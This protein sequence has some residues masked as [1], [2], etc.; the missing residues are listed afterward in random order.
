M[1]SASSSSSSGTSFA[2]ADRIAR[3]LLLD[4]EDLDQSMLSY[5]ETRKGAIRMQNLAFAEYEDEMEAIGMIDEEYEFEQE[6]D[7]ANVDHNI[8]RHLN[9]DKEADDDDWE[10]IDGDFEEEEEPNNEFK[11]LQ[12]PKKVKKTYMKEEKTRPPSM[13][14]KKDMREKMFSYL[15]EARIN[16][17]RLELAYEV[18]KNDDELDMKQIDAMAENLYVVRKKNSTALFDFMDTYQSNPNGKV[19]GNDP[20]YMIMLKSLAKLGTEK[21]AVRMEMSH[22]NHKQSKKNH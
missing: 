19:W 17:M 21:S 14:Q 7:N 2:F 9:I 1:S 13:N 20:D 15:D 18:A 4:S 11:I 5:A 12:G 8:A 16:E 10:D 3:Q 6:D 22:K